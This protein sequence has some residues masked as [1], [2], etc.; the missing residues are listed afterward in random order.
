MP[1]TAPTLQTT[2]QPTAIQVHHSWMDVLSRILQI[3]ASVAPA[4]AAPFVSDKTE[5]IIASESGIAG[6]LA[7]ALSSGNSTSA[8]Q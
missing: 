6:A 8:Q 3:A 7:G 2:T 4:A 1:S 5:Q